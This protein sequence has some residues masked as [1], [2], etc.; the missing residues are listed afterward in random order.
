MRKYE[1]YHLPAQGFDF[2]SVSPY[3]PEEVSKPLLVLSE[4]ALSKMDQFPKQAFKAINKHTCIDCR[5]SSETSITM[6]V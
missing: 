1:K 2:D 4:E 6:K 5:H 3:Q